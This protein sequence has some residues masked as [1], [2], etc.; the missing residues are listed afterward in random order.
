MPGDHVSREQRNAD[1]L[2]SIAATR[3]LLQRSRDAIARSAALIGRAHDRN[4]DLRERLAR[5]KRSGKAVAP[6]ILY[7]A[8]ENDTGAGW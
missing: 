1:S 5:N 6:S 8:T 7:R 4:A 3:Q 2:Q